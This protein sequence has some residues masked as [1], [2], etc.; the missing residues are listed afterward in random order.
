MAT[1]EA[2]SER[3]SDKIRAL[4]GPLVIA[5]SL[6]YQKKMRMTA[7]E[8]IAKAVDDA[9]WRANVLAGCGKRSISYEFVHSG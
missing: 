7:D 9:T 8:A 1:L 3:E 4:N 6:Q 2:E 5:T